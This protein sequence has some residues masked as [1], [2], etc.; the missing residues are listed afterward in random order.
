M[1]KQVLR[2]K[3]STT[4]AVT[5][6]A[7]AAYTNNTT[8]QIEVRLISDRAT[9]VSV[10]ADATDQDALV[11]ADCIEL[12]QVDPGK[13]VSVLREAAETDGT[14]WVTEIQRV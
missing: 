1:A 9:H 3:A 11:P 10:I 2:F 13:T 5:T 7:V 6:A 8:D 12:L 4:A 14:V